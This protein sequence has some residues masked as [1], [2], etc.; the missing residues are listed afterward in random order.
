MDK[1][2]IH[3]KP[4]QEILFRQYQ[5]SIKYDNDYS[6]NRYNEPTEPDRNILPELRNNIR[7]LLKLLNSNQWGQFESYLQYTYEWIIKIGREN[8]HIWGYDNYLTSTGTWGVRY[9][10][11][12][13]ITYILEWQ[14]PVKIGDRF[15]Y[16]SMEIP[17]V[18]TRIDTTWHGVEWDI[19]PI[20]DINAWT[21]CY[22]WY[23]A[24]HN[25]SDYTKHIIK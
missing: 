19:M 22:S 24:K 7:K 18:I 15:K 11:F 8:H 4:I 3:K 2:D 16:D 17:G 1:I 14:C 10:K 21:I 23:T 6:L 5:G 25:E 20:K 13:D 9:S 12:R